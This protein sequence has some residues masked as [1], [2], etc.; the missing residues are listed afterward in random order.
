M[1][2]EVLGKHNEY[3]Y[4]SIG[5]K[6]LNDLF[7]TTKSAS[8]IL[9]CFSQIDKNTKG[10]IFIVDDSHELEGI[11]TDGDLRRA[12]LKGAE[13]H[14]SPIDYINR[15]FIYLSSNFSREQALKIF[16]QGKKF[17]PILNNKKLVDVIFPENISYCEANKIYARSKAPVRISF[18]GGGTDLTSFFLDHGGAVLNSTISLYAHCI[19]IKR[20]DLEV[21]I[22]SNDFN[23]I[24]SYPTYSQI[25]YNGNLDLIKAV[26]VLLKPKFGFDLEITSDFPLHSGLG[27]SSAVLTAVISAFN[28]FREDKLNRYEIAELAFQAERI[29]L[30]VSG[31]WQDQYASVFGGFNFIEFNALKN[32]VFS[33][34]VPHEV[35]NELEARLVLCFSGKEH[36]IGKI[37]D[38]QKSQMTQSQVIDFA[39]RARQIAYEMKSALLRGHIDLFG[40]LLN[41]TWS[42]KKKFADG[43]SNTYVDE[44]YDFALENGAIGG[45]I[46][47]A[48]GGGFFLFQ[49]Q[50]DKKGMLVNALKNRNLL[51]KDFIFDDRG[52]RSWLI[53]SHL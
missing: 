42:L 14:D 2:E 37:H 8:S 4:F 12:F 36:P 53:R 11:L 10:F 5:N 25:E 7:L 45:K 52:V 32:E 24:V 26:I 30:S 18:G 9:E 49:S 35:I 13:P 15:N 34:K 19:I 23:I 38:N 31:G 3:Q 48:G 22:L 29:E 43:I 1:V 40:K 33:L 16:D 41:E 46:L 50:I 17:I 28:E 20:N 6:M 47:G 21:R 51:V 39:H 27:G 44:I